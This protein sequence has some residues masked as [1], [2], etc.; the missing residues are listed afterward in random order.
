MKKIVPLVLFISLFFTQSAFASSNESSACK[1]GEERFERLTRELKSTNE[2]ILSYQNS[3]AQGGLFSQLY[4]GLAG[5]LM[6]L[7]ENIMENIQESISLMN[8]ECSDTAKINASTTEL[9]KYL[10]GFAGDVLKKFE[11]SMKGNLLLLDEDSDAYSYLKDYSKFVVDSVK[12]TPDEKMTSFDKGIRNIINRGVPADEMNGRLN[13]LNDRLS[14]GKTFKESIG[15]TFLSDVLYKYTRKDLVNSIPVEYRGEFEKLAKK[16]SSEQADLFYSSDLLSYGFAYTSTIRS[17]MNEVEFLFGKL[18]EGIDGNS[19]S[20]ASQNKS[21]GRIVGE[22]KTAPKPLPPISSDKNPVMKFKKKKLKNA[23]PDKKE[24]IEEE[25]IDTHLTI[26][27]NEAY[28]AVNDKEVAGS[29]YATELLIQEK[30]TTI[31]LT[32]EV[33]SVSI[34]KVEDNDWTTNRDFIES[35]EGVMKYS[36]EVQEKPLLD[37]ISSFPMKLNYVDLTS[38]NLNAWVDEENQRIFFSKETEPNLLYEFPSE[39]VV[40]LLEKKR[41]KSKS[42]F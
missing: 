7:R 10:D 23:S 20:L 9:E 5:D 18:S 2:L 15:K 26:I 8:R 24:E 31:P 14:I 30:E 1:S 28:K 37:H 3:S 17:T 11:S 25:I 19:S 22:Q 4:S 33:R 35:F 32:N 6:N 29:L 36:E 27:T 42:L 21:F 12:P 34:S 38:E 13:F 40:D 16:S 41:N 39:I